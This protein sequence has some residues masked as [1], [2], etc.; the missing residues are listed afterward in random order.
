M[1]SA[2]QP[3]KDAKPKRPPATTPEGRENQLIAAAI[4]LAE[5]QLLDGTASSQVITHF[6]KLASSRNQVE[7]QK[8]EHENELLKAR[9][10]HLKSMESN[11]ELYAN[12]LNAM[13]RYQGIDVEED[14]DYE[15]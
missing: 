6:L 3:G 4:D 5:R 10:E 1:V 13:K 8:I 14:D 9:V 12:A 15:D 2:R 7:V 11:E